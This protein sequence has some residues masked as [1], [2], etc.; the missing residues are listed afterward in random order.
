MVTG[1]HED[2]QKHGYIRAECMS[3]EGKHEP[4]THQSTWFS[5]LLMKF[6]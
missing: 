6:E 1:V 5:K 2:D 4:L 3:V